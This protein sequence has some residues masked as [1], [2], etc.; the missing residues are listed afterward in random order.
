M[1]KPDKL[2]AKRKNLAQARQNKP[3]TVA[4]LSAVDA[5]SEA[6]DNTEA[7]DDGEPIELVPDPKVWEEFDVTPQTGDRWTKHPTLGFP[8]K[9]KI[10]DRNYRNRRDLEAF[11]KRLIAIAIRNRAT[12]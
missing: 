6:S 4:A 2:A 10:G 11:K 1:A 12:T 8:A 3:T 5:S 9:I 7:S